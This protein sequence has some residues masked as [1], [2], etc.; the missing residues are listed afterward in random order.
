MKTAKVTKAVFSRSYN[1]QFGV[2]YS[3]DIEFD[4]GDKGQY[5]SKKEQQDKFVVGK[6]ASYEITQKGNYFNVKPVSL[7]PASGGFSRGGASE[8][9][10]KQKSIVKQSSLKAALDFFSANGFPTSVTHY[11][12]EHTGELSPIEDSKVTNNKIK[13]VLTVADKFA[14]WVLA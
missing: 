8:S 12:N 14:E 13:A 11:I 7:T 3:H 1:T 2:M 9:P 4:N 5:S 6:E 10:E